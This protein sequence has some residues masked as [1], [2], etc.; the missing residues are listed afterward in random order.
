VSASDEEDG[1]IGNGFAPNP[2]PATWT[3][4][5]KETAMRSLCLKALVLLMLVSVLCLP[6]CTADAGERGPGKY[7]G[8]VV[9]DR[10]GG[11]TLYS[12][13]Y[14]MYVSEKVKGKLREYGGT[15]VRIDAKEVSQPMN[16]GDGL[17]TDLAYLG[18]APPAQNWVVLDRLSLQAVPA[19][20]EGEKPAIDIVVKN[21]GD[22]DITVFSAELAPTLLAKNPGVAVSDG[23]SFALITRQGFLVGGAEPRTKGSGVH[24]GQ[25][26]AWKA[27]AALPQ[28]FALKPGEERKVRVTFEL[29]AGEYDFLAGYGGGVHEGKGLASNLVAFDVARDGKAKFVKVPGR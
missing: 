9:Y 17:I 10:W 23:P 19:S 15:S 7:S 1:S 27:D 20:Q 11:C 2:L 12:G 22:R 24:G 16:P 13:I 25:P 6:P 26:Y 14:V 5:R 8:V 28:Q 4:T 29:P 3:L 21:R 18:A